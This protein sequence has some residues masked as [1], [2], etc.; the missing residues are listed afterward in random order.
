M[1]IFDAVKKSSKLLNKISANKH[2]HTVVR[3]ASTISVKAS[4]AAV[5][6]VKEGLDSVSGQKMY[7][8]VQER[9]AVQD[10]YNDVLAA[11]LHEAL[12]RI[13]TLEGIIH[14]KE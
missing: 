8:L 14:A 7:D 13:E 11:K 12:E 1:N 4:E 2:V 5:D 9:L 6:V 3:T 10:Q